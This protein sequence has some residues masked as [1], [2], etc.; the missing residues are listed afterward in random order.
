MKKQ[1]YIKEFKKLGIKV[2]PLPKDYN[3]N[4]FGENLMSKFCCNFSKVSYSA[5][6]KYIKNDCHSSSNP[7]RGDCY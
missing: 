1:D 6:T 3:P 2:E 5:N 4:I 7:T